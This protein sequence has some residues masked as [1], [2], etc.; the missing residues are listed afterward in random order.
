MMTG[1]L[2]NEAHGL[3]RLPNHFGLV[4]EWIVSCLKGGA[5]NGEI[6]NRIHKCVD[7]E[8]GVDIVRNMVRTPIVVGEVESFGFDLTKWL[9]AFD[10]GDV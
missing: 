5:M 2:F 7:F 9:K 10:I 6:F 3:G 1:M 8:Y 4:F